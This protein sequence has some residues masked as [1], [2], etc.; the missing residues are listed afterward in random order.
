MPLPQHRIAIFGY[1]RTGTNFLVSS[2]DSIPGVTFHPEPFNPAAVHLASGRRDALKAERDADPQGFLDRLTRECTTPI[3]GVKLLPNHA[4]AVRER[5]IADPA[6]R[7]IVLFRPNFLAVH[8]S[9]L[10]ATQT[11]VW[12][13]TEG[14]AAVEAEPLWFEPK[15]FHGARDAF[16]TFYDEVTTSLDAAGKPFLPLNYID[17]LDPLMLRNVAR[18][19]GVTGAFEMSSRLVKQGGWDVV[20]AFQNGALVRETLAAIRR[21]NWAVEGGSGLA[22]ALRDVGSLG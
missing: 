21:P 17:L 18:H 7:C 14:R 6:W 15:R 4:P 2:L 22:E 1:Q 10:R 11:G 5:I 16:R 12:A 9:Q 20:S 8:A 13:Q 19:A 3:L